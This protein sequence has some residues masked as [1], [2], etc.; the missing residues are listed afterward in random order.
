MSD[1]LPGAPDIAYRG[2]A[3]HIEDVALARIAEAAGTPIYCYSSAQIERNYRRFA[4][5][6]ADR[7]ALLCYSVKANPN[8]AVVATLA[9]LGSGADVVSEGEF[10]RALAAGIPGSRIVFSGI[11]KTEAELRF[12]LAHGVRQINVEDRKSTRLN[13]SH[14]SR[15]RMPSSA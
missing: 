14:Y 11:G 10:R 13:S 4:A 1:T 12:A 7:D 5:A 9:R 15:S 2:G 8:L 6:F 3:L